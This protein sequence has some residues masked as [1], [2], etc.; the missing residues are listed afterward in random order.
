MKIQT[1]MTQPKIL[2]ISRSRIPSD[3][4][5]C[6]QVLKMCAGFAAHAEVELAA[7]YFREDARLRDTLQERFALARPFTVRWL[8]YPHFRKRF[9]VRGFALAATVYAKV[10]GFRLA[11]TRDPWVAYWLARSGIHTGFESHDLKED[12][13]YPI[14]QMLVSDRS[15]SPDLRGVFCITRRLLEDSI[16]AGARDDILHVAPDGVDLQRFQNPMSQA[17]A[18]NALGLP[19]QGPWIVH[20]G[21]IYEGRGGEELIQALAKIPG[22]RLLFAGGKPADVARVRAIAAQQ[23]LTDRVRFEGMVPNARIPL[24]LWA[25]D[26]LVMP[27]TT[28]TPIMASISP[29]KM[30]EY[31][32]AERP[33]VSTDFPT[34]REVLHDGEN[35]VL[36]APD[37]PATLAAGIRR[38]L[39][40]PGLGARIARQA[41]QDVE[42]YTW[43]RRAEKIMGILTR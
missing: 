11:Y 23:G 27:Y 13:R 21:H 18:R 20:A 33:I 26:V 25:A 34:L 41:R 9:A 6:V 3:Q 36:V 43:E 19:E 28:R 42:Q 29:M 10:R 39:D 2:Y 7:P 16:A 37:S 17:E 40:D 22:T 8:P 32:A 12:R 1:A 24:Y 14:W 31:M 35:A 38:L 4:A 30:F 5:N 15:L